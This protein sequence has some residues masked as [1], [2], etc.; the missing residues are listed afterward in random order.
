MLLPPNW[1]V[2][3]IAPLKG[4]CVYLATSVRRLSMRA[5]L[6]CAE[7]HLS[8]HGH[9]TLHTSPTTEAYCL[10]PTELVRQPVR[11]CLQLLFRKL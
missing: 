11:Y 4:S 2:V 6:A 7:L 5:G 3:V 9:T 8:A 1:E 10:P